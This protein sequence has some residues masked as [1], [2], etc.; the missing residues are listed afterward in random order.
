MPGG[1]QKVSQNKNINESMR[2]YKII[3]QTG[4]QES[5]QQQT[6]LAQPM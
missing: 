6:Q 5:M 2:A 4:N 3:K 1:T